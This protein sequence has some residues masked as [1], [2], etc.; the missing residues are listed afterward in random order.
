MTSPIIIVIDYLLGNISDLA[1]AFA[2]F[3]E[4]HPG[5][6]AETILIETDK[7]D[8]VYEKPPQISNA[9]HIAGAFW[10]KPIR[11]E[12]LD[13]FAKYVPDNLFVDGGVSH[14][15]YWRNEA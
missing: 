6:L 13:I 11:A 2:K 10:D 4:E 12:L 14:Y 1:D 5:F 7:A 9:A 3:D 15:F 8:K